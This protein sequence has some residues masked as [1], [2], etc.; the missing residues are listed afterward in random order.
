M[1]WRLGSSQQ[2]V[3]VA[4]A[5]APYS[6]VTSQVTLQAPGVPLATWHS[7]GASCGTPGVVAPPSRRLAFPRAGPPARAPRRGR[8]KR[9]MRDLWS[10]RVVQVA[11]AISEPLD[12]ACTH[13]P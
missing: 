8:G 9:E 13:R 5:V 7:V 11:G 3:L 10:S 4:V 6:A 12:G 2:D 1:V